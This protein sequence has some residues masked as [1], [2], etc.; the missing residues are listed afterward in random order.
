MFAMPALQAL[1]KSISRNVSPNTIEINVFGIAI[2]ELGRV[3]D[4]ACRDQRNWRLGGRST[5]RRGSFLL[6]AMRPKAVTEYSSRHTDQGDLRSMLCLEG[7]AKC[8]QD[9]LLALM[10][11]L[12]KLSSKVVSANSR[13]A[14][15]R[16]LTSVSFS[17]VARTETGSSRM[18]LALI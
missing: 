1:I 7:S 17:S 3:L 10:K 13:R 15:C 14:W 11:H 16:V 18:D 8:A 4:I 5:N 12:L 2:L 6:T 9:C